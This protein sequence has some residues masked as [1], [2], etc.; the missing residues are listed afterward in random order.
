[1]EHRYKSQTRTHLKTAAEKALRD[2][3]K[4][5]SEDDTQEL[6]ELASLVDAVKTDIMRKRQPS[7][8]HQIKDLD[9]DLSHIE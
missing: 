3:L 7:E 5:L 8:N 4:V 2:Y 1:M 9:L 6:D